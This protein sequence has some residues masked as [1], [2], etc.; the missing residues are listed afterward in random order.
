M[1]GR[2]AE[3]IPTH[4]IVKGRH[5]AGKTS[6]SAIARGGG[7]KERDCTKCANCLFENW[8]SASR[9]KKGVPTS[10]IMCRTS[11]YNPNNYGFLVRTVD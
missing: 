2:R 9:V 8:D 7:L 1:R 3:I 11:Q 6:D 4:L 10:G 5:Y